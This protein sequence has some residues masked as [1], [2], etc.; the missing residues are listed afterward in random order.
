MRVE[1]FA[2]GS[3]DCPLVLLYGSNP[4]HASTLSAALQNL[5]NGFETRIAIHELLGFVSISGC[6]LFASVA[7]TDV[8]VVAITPAVVFD[9]SLRPRTWDDTVALIEPFCHPNAVSRHFQYLDGRGD[10]RLMISTDRAW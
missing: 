9:C 2:N 4:T 3:A 7:E 6:Q 5:A 8:G 10:I 1:Y